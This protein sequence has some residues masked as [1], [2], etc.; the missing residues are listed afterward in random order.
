MCRSP[1]VLKSDKLSSPCRGH[2]RWWAL[3][4]DAGPCAAV[5]FR[6]RELHPVSGALRCPQLAHLR[7]ELNPSVMALVVLVYGV[8][9]FFGIAGEIT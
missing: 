7:K 5:A 8:P 9:F 2:V 1:Q 4:Q 3:A 6:Q